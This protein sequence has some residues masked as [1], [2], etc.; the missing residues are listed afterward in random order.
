[1][2][3]YSIFL[4]PGTSQLFAYVEFTDQAQWNAVAGTDACQRWWGHMGDIMPSNEDGSPT[5]ENLREVFHMAGPSA[6]A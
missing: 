5:S 2:V 1:M 4:H 6:R 3:T